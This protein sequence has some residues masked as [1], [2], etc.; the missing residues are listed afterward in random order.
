MRK[1]FKAWI[2]VSWK[3]RSVRNGMYLSLEEA[4]K[5]LMK[6]SK[7]GNSGDWGI[8]ETELWKDVAGA[9]NGEDFTRF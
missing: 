3:T 4:K 5:E 6:V 7:N 1:K 2:V 8:E 9:D